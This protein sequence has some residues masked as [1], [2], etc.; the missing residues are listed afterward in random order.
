MESNWS[1]TGFL[2]VDDDEFAC[3]VITSVLMHL[4]ATRI[5]CAT[6]GDTALRLAAELRPDFVLLDIYMPKAD[7]WTLL[8]QLRR[9]CP[10]AAI[11]MVTGSGMQADFLKSIDE[12]ADGFCIKPVASDIMQRA[13]LGA[14]RR[15]HQ[16]A[17]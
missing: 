6:D 14:Q 10:Q 11:I 4:G 2:V 16:P 13:L 9:A 8:G 12:H 7:G 1:Q 3:D 15:R 5:S 17:A